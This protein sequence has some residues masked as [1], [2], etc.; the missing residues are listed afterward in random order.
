MTTEKQIAA[1]IQA[2]ADP[3]LISKMRTFPPSVV[4]PIV[5]AAEEIVEEV[6]EKRKTRKSKEG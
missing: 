6:K 3:V 5:K 2:G 4:A 1:L